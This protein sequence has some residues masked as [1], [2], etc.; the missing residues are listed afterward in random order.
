MLINCQHD[1]N[2]VV[3][4]KPFVWYMNHSGFVLATNT[5]TI[6]MDYYTDPE[7]V[8]SPYLNSDLPLIFLVSHEHYDHWNP[9]IL[10]LR[11][12]TPSY[13]ILD[14][15]CR[16][17]F[18]ETGFPIDERYMR[19]VHSPM[20]L[21]SIGFEQLPFEDF[22]VFG[23]TDA[24]SSFFFRTE[25]I[26]YFHAGDLNNWDWKD[27]ESSAMEANYREKLDEIQGYLSS[28]S[29][30]IDVAFVAVD[31]R[32]MDRAISGAEIFI[33]YFA[34]KILL[35]MHLNGGTDYPQVLAKK[36]ARSGTKIVN[37]QRPGDRIDEG[38]RRIPPC[39]KE[40]Y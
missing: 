14:E 12:Q 35:P 25:G 28:C 39:V 38:G 37:L 24:G 22:R 33:D 32:L 20:G 4:T 9:D 6:V 40:V 7:A 26:S 23:S 36:N 18:K 15:A 27:E 3:F 10:N 5:A 19:F 17:Y 31:G 2:I 21:D 34:P 29:G 16:N 30:T 1:P 8:L 11:S 13:Y